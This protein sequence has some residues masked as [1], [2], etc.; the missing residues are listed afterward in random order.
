MDQPL[1][2][3]F[4][5]YMGEYHPAEKKVVVEFSP[6]D[7][8]LTELQQD[9]LKKLA[10]SRYNPEKETIKMSCESFEH[11]AQNKRYLAS[12]VEKLVADAKV[13]TQSISLGLLNAIWGGNMLTLHMQDPTDTFEDI[14]L[15]L[16]HH[17]FRVKPKF[18]REW[19]MSDERVA[20][21]E[22][23]REETKLLEDLKKQ[24][25]TLVDGV[26]IINKAIA[27]R[28]AKEA[29]PELVAASQQTRQRTKRR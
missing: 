26:A 23:Y 22:A 11:Q 24:D 25:G 4:T 27:A 13:R 12:L 7:F 3:R 16:R 2:F 20:Q 8:G 15:D 1:R 21:I 9:K 17:K 29:V 14:P 10:G 18:P 6:A 19:R 28:S 5:S